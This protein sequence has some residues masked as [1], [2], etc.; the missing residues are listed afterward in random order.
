MNRF[1]RWLC[2]RY[3]PAYCREA[4]MNGIAELERRVS[5]LQ[6]ENDRLRAYINGMETAMRAHR[7]IIIRNEARQSEL[8]KCSD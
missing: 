6:H 1:K 8:G 3:L 5:K 7:R 4:A 2:E